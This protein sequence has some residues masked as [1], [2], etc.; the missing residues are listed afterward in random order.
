MKRGE[1]PWRSAAV[2]AAVLLS[3]IA[4]QP[5]HA[6]VGPSN[7]DAAVPCQAFQRLGYGGWTAI[8]PVTLNLDNGVRM[9]FTP[10]TRLPPGST[11]DG[12]AIPVIITRHCGNL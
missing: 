4:A 9:S 5:V 3:G 7:Y 2:A 8:A 6:G 1:N 12:V 10:G 11:V